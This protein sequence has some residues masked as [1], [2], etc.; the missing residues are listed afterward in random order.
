MNDDLLIPINFVDI[1]D[2]VSNNVNAYCIV[3]NT[4]PREHYKDKVDMK[5]PFYASIPQTPDDI[6]LTT[7]MPGFCFY[8][9]R[10]CIKDVGLF[11]EHFKCWFGDDDYQNRIIKYANKN[12][13]TPI[14]RINYVCLSLWW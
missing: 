9:S 10:E 6:S 2:L 13:Y 12:N 4:P 5:F 7:W 11:D 3:P 8:L 14:L 1:M